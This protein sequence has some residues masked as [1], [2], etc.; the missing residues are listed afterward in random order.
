M[1]K[2]V[3]FSSALLLSAA[4]SFAADAPATATALAQAVDLSDAKAAGLVVTG[5]LVAVGVTLWGARI[6]LRKFTPK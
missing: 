4:N 6:V 3:L 2:I 5:L 1:K